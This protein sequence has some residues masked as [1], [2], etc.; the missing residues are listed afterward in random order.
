MDSG[1]PGSRNARPAILVAASHSGAGKTTTVAIL[2]R[3]LRDRGLTVQAFKIGP[4]FIDTAYHTEAT[5]RPAINLDLWMMGPDAV[6]R[7]FHH[8]SAD[9]DISVIES[10]G[11][12]FDGA[13]G[14]EE[15]SAAHLAKLL[16]VPVVVVLDVWGM[17]RTTGAV[18]TG[19]RD[20]DPE[21]T[22]AGCILNRTGSDRHARMV[23]D[24]L[25]P[26]L[27]D[28]VVG[29]V[30]HQAGLA[31]PERHL[32][33][34]TVEENPAPR[35]D[36]D[37][38]YRSAGRGLDVDRLLAV[39]GHRTTGSADP[40][41]GPT[42]DAATSGT[43]GRSAPARARLAVARDAAFCFYYE[44][45]LRLLRA[46]GFELV[47]FRPTSDP[48]LPDGTDAVYLGGGYPESFAADLAAN[49]ALAGELRRRAVAGTPIYAEC[50]GLM[51]L[52]ASLTGFDGTRHP[53]TGVLP[54]DVVM[55]PAH[56]AIRYVEVHTRQD[57]PLGPAGTTLRGQEFHQSRI[58][59]DPALPPLFDVT[60][61]DGTTS[62]AG[63]AVGN[64]VAS[65]IHVHLASHPHVARRLLG[66]ALAARGEQT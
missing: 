27:R 18:L 5:G 31:V 14:T 44:E 4:D 17:T 42:R 1:S 66:A 23:L 52:A 9:A 12:L 21:L 59:G 46:A 25:R 65:Y 32:G 39:A 36:R 20:F 50:G 55:D 51:Y 64:V 3:A 58:T 60:S 10:M 41:T 61:S 34:V 16:G 37:D 15:G 38:A 54:L 11:A 40:T 45:N 35:V 26:D 7:S 33:L 19:M 49:T 28:L 48:A 29:A 57:S 6:R 63:Y 43:V 56:L 53:M 62:V 47:P 2:L 22:I 13:D 8:F 30:S 24:A